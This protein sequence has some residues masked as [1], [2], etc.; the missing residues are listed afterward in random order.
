MNSCHNC[1]YHAFTLIPP[2]SIPDLFNKNDALSPT[3]SQQ[4]QSTLSV[5]HNDLWRINNEIS[6]VQAELHNLMRNRDLL[7][8]SHDRQRLLLSP[9]RSIPPEI[10]AHIFMALAGHELGQLVFPSRKHILLPGQI[11]RY[12]REVA[13]STPSLWASLSF[14]LHPEY[15]LR[16]ME[17]GTTWLARTGEYPLTLQIRNSRYL[18]PSTFYPIIDMILAY[19]PRWH[20]LSLQVSPFVL[21]QHIQRAKGRVSRLQCLSIERDGDGDDSSPVIESFDAFEIV[22]KLRSFHLQS[23]LINRMQVP[24]SQLRDLSFV[25]GPAPSFDSLML[26]ALRSLAVSSEA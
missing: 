15:F 20:T 12:W 5:V 16:E 18:A 1:G 19:A 8:A 26:P 9:V 7:R 25:G 23:G 24:W 17:M 14:D 22:P 13:I 11:C 3:E 2:I 6:R 21:Q 10:L 4:I